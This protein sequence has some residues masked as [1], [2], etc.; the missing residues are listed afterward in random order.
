VLL[1]NSQTYLGVWVIFKMEENKLGNIAGGIAN[2]LIAQI[3]M[4]QILNNLSSLSSDKTY[5][6]IP[7]TKSLD[8]LKNIKRY[9]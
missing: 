3:V 6:Y 2:V 5:N 8:C 4:N 1:L 7:K 9:Y